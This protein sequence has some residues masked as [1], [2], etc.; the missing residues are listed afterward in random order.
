M[1]LL[2]VVTVVLLVVS[3]GSAQDP[4]CVLQKIKDCSPKVLPK[5]DNSTSIKEEC[6]VVSKFQDCLRDGSKSCPA[7]LPSN[8]TSMVSEMQKS[9]DLDCSA[10]KP[11][12]KACPLSSRII[13]AIVIGTLFVA[14]VVGALG[15]CFYMNKR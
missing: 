8:I 4:D 6:C 15:Y 3:T 12:F 7:L 2:Q 9:G 13:G 14:G 10:Y 1:T 5:N 11:L